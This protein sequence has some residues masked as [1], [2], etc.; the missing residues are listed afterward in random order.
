M[1]TGEGIINL[2][3]GSMEQSGRPSLEILRF[4]VVV[5]LCVF[6]TAIDVSGTGNMPRG[7]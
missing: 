4:E 5:C 6:C 1:A 3:T 2:E 7:T